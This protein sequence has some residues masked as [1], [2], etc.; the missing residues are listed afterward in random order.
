MF[1]VEMVTRDAAG[2]V[3]FVVTTNK[4]YYD[5]HFFICKESRCWGYGEEW[6]DGPLCSFGL[7]PFMLICWMYK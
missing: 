6:Y 5:F 2:K 3:D 4:R 7:G 1:K